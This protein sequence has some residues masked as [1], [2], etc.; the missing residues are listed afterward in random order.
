LIRGSRDIKGD[1][2]SKTIP[3]TKSILLQLNS[4]ETV[5]VMEAIVHYMEHATPQDMAKVRTLLGISTKINT[6]ITAPDADQTEV[7]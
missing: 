1:D 7:I 5:A 4:H 2:I 3:D 6:L